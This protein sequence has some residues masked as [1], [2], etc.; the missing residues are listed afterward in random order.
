MKI[1]TSIFIILL[2]GI[3]AVTVLAQGGGKAEPLEIKFAKGKAETTLSGTLSNG[4][5]MEYSFDAKQGQAVTIRNRNTSLFDVR[6]FSDENDLETEFD[7]SPEFRVTLPETGKY[8]LF[9]RKK[10]TDR[11]RKAKF[12]VRISVK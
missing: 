1:R 7:S 5:E 11:P 3:S 6:L 8:Q 2:L 10:M 12:S 9:V 4:Q